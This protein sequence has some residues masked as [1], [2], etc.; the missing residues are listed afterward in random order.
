M[1][2]GSRYIECGAAILCERSVDCQSANRAMRAK[3]LPRDYM[4]TVHSWS[5]MV[6]CVICWSTFYARA[7]LGH[8]AL[9]WSFSTFI[10]TS[11][12]VCTHHPIYVTIRWGYRICCRKSQ[13]LRQNLAWKVGE[14][15]ITRSW[16]RHFYSRQNT[17]F[18]SK[19][20]V[21]IW[22]A[23][24]LPCLQRRRLGLCW[25]SAFS[26]SP[27]KPFTTYTRVND[28]WPHTD[29]IFRGGGDLYASTYGT[30]SDAVEHCRCQLGVGHVGCCLS[31]L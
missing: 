7:Y 2:V 18:P 31:R 25:P 21:V 24:G 30:S 10:D 16:N 22:N 11:G 1:A 15:L 3:S 28:L 23:T 12:Y 20:G 19:H 17:Q 9:L 29:S 27:Q 6:S 13:N 14:R 8:K 5:T 4:A 26:T